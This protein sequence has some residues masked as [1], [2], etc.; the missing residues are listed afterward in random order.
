LYIFEGE[1]REGGGI[2]RVKGESRDEEKETFGEKAR[3]ERKWTDLRERL[4]RPGGRGKR[5]GEK[6]KGI[7]RWS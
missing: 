1:E 7:Q 2:V 3:D 4:W 6:D 5:D